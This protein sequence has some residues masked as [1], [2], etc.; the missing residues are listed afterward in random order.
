MNI[1]FIEP[2]KTT[3]YVL[4]DSRKGVLEMKGRSSPKA[5]VEF[6]Y[7]IMVNMERT[8]NEKG[9]SITANFAFEYFNTSS[10]KCLFDILKK[11]AQL[12]ASGCDVVV[13]W[14]YDEDD[15]DMLE[16]GEDYEDVLGLDFNFIPTEM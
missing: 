10:S 1:F 16:T 11:L 3:P 4:I 15:S 5:S 12:K 13:N 6:F 9:C 8:F 7:P 2:T 14:F